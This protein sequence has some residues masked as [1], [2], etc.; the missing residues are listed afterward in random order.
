MQAENIDILAYRL[1]KNVTVHETDGILQL[2]LSY[3]LKSI[4]IHQHWRDLFKQ[5]SAEQFI[6]FDTIVS[7][8]E[9]PKPAELEFF[10]NDLVCKGFLE[11]RGVFFSGDLP[12]VS[13]QRLSRESD[14]HR[15][16][17]QEFLQSAQELHRAYY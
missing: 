9:S 8:T 11:R 10:L 3:P 12:H 13:V 14:S 4:R 17:Q 6:T 2:V 1:R 16:S 7:V 15:E 5:I